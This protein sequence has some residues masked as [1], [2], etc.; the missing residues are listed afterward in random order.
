MLNFGMV[1]TV[2][3]ATCVTIKTP[4]AKNHI[5]TNAVVNTELFSNFLFN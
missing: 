3:K 4:T 1:P 5:F 2:N